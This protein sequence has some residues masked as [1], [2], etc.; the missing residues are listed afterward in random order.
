VV[1]SERCVHAHIG[2][3]SCRACVDACPRGAWVIDEHMLGIDEGKCDG[4]DLC[5]AA[6]PQGAIQ[7]RLFP[8]LET[9][10][11]GGVAFAACEH[12]GL[13]QRGEGAVACLHALGTADL[14]R[15]YREGARLLVTSRGDCAHCERGGTKPIE[16]RLEEINRLLASRGLE[17]LVQRSLDSGAWA[18]ALRHASEGVAARPRDRR[19]FFRQAI[20]LP[21]E[22]LEAAIADGAGAFAPPGTLLAGEGADALFPFVPEIAP[23][24][25]TWCSACV[26]LC[27]HGAIRVEEEVHGEAAFLIEA[28]RCSGCGICADVCEQGAVSVATLSRSGQRRIGLR[29]ERC[30]A[31]GVD[32]HVPVSDTA[33]ALLC[34]VCRKSNHYADLYQVLE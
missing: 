30:R 33:P 25:C 21:K 4:C 19:A 11:Q 29:R 32:F 28:E 6:C 14:L 7:A 12:A 3:A 2:N 5:V 22:R 10:D 23:G 8:A 1:A 27:P 16:V 9:A 26:R 24:R 18:E 15:L 13:A 34:W 17:P 31:C 20:S